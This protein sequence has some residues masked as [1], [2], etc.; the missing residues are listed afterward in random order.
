MVRQDEDKATNDALDAQEVDD[1]MCK[2]ERTQE[3]TSREL[4]VILMQQR[5]ANIV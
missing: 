2:L 5:K 3:S 4:K 1:V